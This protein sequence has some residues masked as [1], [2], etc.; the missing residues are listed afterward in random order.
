MGALEA[1]ALIPDRLFLLAEEMDAVWRVGVGGRDL[2]LR[3]SRDPDRR[4]GVAG[5]LA[6]LLDLDRRAI[7]V[8]APIPLPSG[9]LVASHEDEIGPVVA[10]LLDYIPGETFAFPDFPGLTERDAA[11]AGGLIARLHDA[12]ESFVPPPGFRRHVPGDI[13]ASCDRPLADV[14]AVV[15]TEFGVGGLIAE[16]AARAASDRAATRNLMIHADLHPANVV[17]RPTGGLAA[18]D[19]EDSGFAPPAYD[20]AVL[21]AATCTNRPELHATFLAAYLDLREVDG[22]Q[23]ALWEAVRHAQDLAFVA[24]EPDHPDFLHQRTETA[25]TMIAAIR[26]GLLAAE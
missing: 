22:K 23:V 10:S 6:W 5:E 17:R 19:F 1:W 11:L 4:A 18:I 9:E 13:A 16:V 8:P 7:P 20:L 21:I 26:A 24:T 14:V 25:A 2:I 12:A 3:L 15:E